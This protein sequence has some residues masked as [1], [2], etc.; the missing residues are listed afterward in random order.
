MAQVTNYAYDKLSQFAV[1]SWKYLEVQKADGTAIKRFTTTDGLTITQVGQTIEYKI[2]ISGVDVSFTGQSV[3]KS[4]I[5]DIATGGQPIAT[6][7]FTEFTFAATED[8]ISIKHVLQIP[9]VVLG[10]V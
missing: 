2:V 10:L 4:V 7:V 9:Q 8:E 6:E 1:G 5:Y 3:A